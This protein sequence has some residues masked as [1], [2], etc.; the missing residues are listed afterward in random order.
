MTLSMIL[1]T[2]TVPTTEGLLRYC[3]AAC[4]GIHLLHVLQRLHF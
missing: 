2:E 1:A 4:L 3:N